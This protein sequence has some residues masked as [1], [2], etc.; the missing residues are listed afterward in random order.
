[1]PPEKFK[2]AIAYFVPWNPTLLRSSVDALFR[3]SSVAAVGGFDSAN[4]AERNIIQE[5]A[6][7][8]YERDVPA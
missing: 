2:L 1:M 3:H 6:L 7:G 4:I 8:Y 5:A